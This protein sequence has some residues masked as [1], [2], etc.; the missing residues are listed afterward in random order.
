MDP[1]ATLERFAQTTRNDREERNELS[2]AYQ[3]WLDMGGFLPSVRHKNDP[4]TGRAFKVTGLYARGVHTYYLTPDAQAP[5]HTSD[6]DP[7]VPKPPEETAHY[8]CE[9]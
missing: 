4:G 5:L 6:Y 3:R 1:F 9:G 8:R 7:I 2:E